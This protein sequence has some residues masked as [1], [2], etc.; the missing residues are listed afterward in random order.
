MLINF[1]KVI[2]FKWY[3]WDGNSRVCLFPNPIHLTNTMHVY[4]MLVTLKILICGLSYPNSHLK[5]S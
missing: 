5:S 3:Y 1:P 2:E 4:A